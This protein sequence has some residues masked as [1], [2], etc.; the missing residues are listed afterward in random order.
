M[1]QRQL[2]LEEIKELLIDPWHILVVDTLSN[3]MVICTYG[4]GVYD[5][6]EEISVDHEIAG[7][8]VKLEEESV[9]FYDSLDDE[10]LKQKVPTAHF[11]DIWRESAYGPQP[12]EAKLKAV[13]LG[14]A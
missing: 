5:I 10:A 6:V 11:F 3:E 2:N 1:S 14:L 12:N 7:L 8:L 9:I 13:E 4:K